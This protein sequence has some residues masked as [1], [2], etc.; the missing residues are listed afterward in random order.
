MAL[1]GKS[2]IEEEEAKTQSGE[3]EDDQSEFDDIFPTTLLQANKLFGSCMFI[4]IIQS[5]L[6]FMVYENVEFGSSTAQQANE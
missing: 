1:T 6:I 4:F 2:L 5:V 3:S